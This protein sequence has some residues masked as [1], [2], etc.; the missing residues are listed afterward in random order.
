MIYVAGVQEDIS[1]FNLLRNITVTI[2]EESITPPGSSDIFERAYIY[3]ATLHIE[4]NSGDKLPQIG[5]LFLGAYEKDDLKFP[6]GATTQTVGSG[7]GGISFSHLNRYI[8]PGN[9]DIVVE[10]Y[11]DDSAL[12]CNNVSLEKPLYFLYNLV[13]GQGFE[14]VAVSNSINQ[15]LKQIACGS[16]P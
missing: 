13:V 14:S 3:R 15:K 11:I 6:Y 7:S 16:T 12:K 9:S 1:Y 4:N 8:Y 5:K 2:K 10:L